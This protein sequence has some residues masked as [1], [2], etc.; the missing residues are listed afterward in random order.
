MSHRD[1]GF[2]DF[3]SRIKAIEEPG[4]SSAFTLRVPH[5]DTFTLTRTQREER[6]L[7]HFAE[8][9]NARPSGVDPY[10]GFLNDSDGTYE[11]VP[12]G[13][14][15]LFQLASHDLVHTSLEPRAFDDYATKPR[16]LRG[17]VLALETVFGGGPIG[18]PHAYDRQ[19]ADGAVPLRTGLFRD[20][21]LSVKTRH[22]PPGDLPRA[23]YNEHEPEELSEHYTEVLIA[24]QRN[25]DNNILAQLT[26]LFHRLYNAIVAKTP[27]VSLGPSGIS[28]PPRHRARIA[29]LATIRIYRRI[30][31]HDL[32]PKLM[33]PDV[34]GLYQVDAPKRQLFTTDVEALSH[35][36]AAASRVA[37]SMV[38]EKYFLRDGFPIDL[39][40]LISTSSL[41]YVKSVP[42]QKSWEIDWSLFF[43]EAGDIRDSTNWAMRLGPHIPTGLNKAEAVQSVTPKYP[44]GTPMRDLIAGKWAELRS[45]KDLIDTFRHGGIGMGTF[46]EMQTSDIVNRV[47]QAGFQALG[48]QP[49]GNESAGMS[50]VDV[51]DIERTPPLTLYLTFEALSE[52]D[53]GRTYGPLGSIII[54]DSFLPVFQQPDISNDSEKHAG[55]LE[56]AVFPGDPIAS[57][58]E[59]LRRLSPA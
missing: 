19:V 2:G 40:R 29:R 37:H 39:R 21:S 55:Y 13:Y 25:D 28:L 54:G 17:E 36:G 41:H 51:G 46:G 49:A 48:V 3:F 53:R 43:P 38:R 7:I 30:L 9:L 24:D 16:N 56:A 10:L 57:M 32:L 18:C 47:V 26:V 33:H 52:G 14:T 1:I 22:G 35:F 42:T 15:Y 8:L 6:A 34:I 12:A 4:G 20:D 59:L 58:P 5:G 11:G 44:P 45:A 50:F 23:R 31:R 27:V